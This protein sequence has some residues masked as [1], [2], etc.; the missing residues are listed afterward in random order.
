IILVICFIAVSNSRLYVS[1]FRASCTF[2]VDTDKD[3]CSKPAPGLSLRE[4]IVAPEGNPEPDTIEFNM[5]FPATIALAYPFPTITESLAIAGLG[6]DKLTINGDDPVVFNTSEI[7]D[8]N[9]R[10]KAKEG[11]D[12]SRLTLDC[13]LVRDNVGLLRGIRAAGN[14]SGKLTVGYVLFTVL[15]DENSNSMNNK[16]GGIYYTSMTPNRSTD[17]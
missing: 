14:S 4:A 17:Q 16:G 13:S 1:G 12:I 15:G 6:P 2:T 11:C 7:F 10:S 5:T 9:T 3:S 8:I